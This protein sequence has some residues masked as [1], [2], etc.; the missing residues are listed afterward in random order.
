MEFIVPVSL[1]TL[2]T[3]RLRF[4]EMLKLKVDVVHGPLKSDDLL[5][6]DKTV[7]LYTL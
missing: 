5:D 4:E 2:S 6:V 1:I 3:I 7:E